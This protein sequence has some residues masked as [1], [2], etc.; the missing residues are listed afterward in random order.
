M[1][2]RTEIIKT[3]TSR[4]LGKGESLTHQAMTFP[5]M[6]HPD[7]SGE[8]C[9][10]TIEAMIAAGEL[11]GG[12]RRDWFTLEIDPYVGSTLKG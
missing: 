9:K 12:P 6:N 7:Y 2:Y 4:G 3:F 11:S 8:A 1:D 10:A 5:L